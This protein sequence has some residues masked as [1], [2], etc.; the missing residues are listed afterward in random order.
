MP[1]AKRSHSVLKTDPDW[2]ALP[3]DLPDP[4]RLLI[5]RALV[6]DRRRRV[7]DIST[8]LFLLN[9]AAVVAPASSSHPG[10]SPPRDRLARR[11]HRHRLLAGAALA[12]IGWQLLGRPAPPAVQR[13]SLF[14]PAD[15]PVVFF[16]WPNQSLAISPDGT[17]DR[18]HQC[19]PR[20]SA[21]SGALS[22]KSVHSPVSQSAICPGRFSRTSRS[23][24]QTDNPSRFSRGT[25]N[26]RRSRSPAA[27]PPSRW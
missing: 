17:A 22:F 1:S 26:S 19:E 11:W 5:E 21:P 7:A 6:K 3:A 10:R 18:L 25:G 23:F 15:R 14:L 12:T 16:Y 8:A 9:E 13:V 20:C 4:I 27:I 24:L 2:R